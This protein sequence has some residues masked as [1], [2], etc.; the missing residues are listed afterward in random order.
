MPR[1]SS[2]TFVSMAIHGLPGL[3]KQSK[4]IVNAHAEYLIGA[5][6]NILAGQGGVMIAWLTGFRLLGIVLVHGGEVADIHGYFLTP[7]IRSE[8][9]CS[10][11]FNCYA[12]VRHQIEA[13][14]ALVMPL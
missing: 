4:L 8:S 5:G 12:C 13:N 10:N 3:A 1:V 2:I 11:Q 14:D 6:E 9:V 7:Q